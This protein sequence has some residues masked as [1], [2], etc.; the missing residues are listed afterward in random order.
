MVSSV[1]SG[2]AQVRAGK[3]SAGA[4][5]PGRKPRDERKGSVLFGFSHSGIGFGGAAV[6]IGPALLGVALALPERL[7]PTV[8]CAHGVGGSDLEVFTGRFSGRMC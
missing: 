8:D 4:I 6:S 3:A 1:A 5:R 2:W 7:E